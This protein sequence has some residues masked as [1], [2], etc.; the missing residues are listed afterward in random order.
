MKLLEIAPL[1]PIVS[2][3]LGI[4]T[5]L[6]IPSFP[7]F[8]GSVVAAAAAWLL[9]TG[10]S[11]AQGG[12]PAPEDPKPANDKVAKP[13]IPRD[14]VVDEHLREEYGVTDLTTPVN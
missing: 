5:C 9:L 13:T 12:K 3:S 1:R 6:E 10:S 11:L 4:L 7:K 14:L 2:C 8:S